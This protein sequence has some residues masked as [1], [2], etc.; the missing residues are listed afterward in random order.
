MLDG[1]RDEASVAGLRSTR[2]IT[3]RRLLVVQVV[4]ALVFLQGALRDLPDNTAAYFFGL[5][6]GCL[7]WYLVLVWLL[8]R[9]T[10]GFT[11]SDSSGRQHQQ[12]Q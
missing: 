9:P 12:Q 2:E 5:S 11:T 7:V 1:V 3:T 6:V 8:S 10:G 4:T